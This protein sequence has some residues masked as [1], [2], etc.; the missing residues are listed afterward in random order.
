M[1]PVIDHVQITVKDM[2]VAL[3]FYDQLMP[4]LG[5]DLEKRINAVVG[6]H[7]LHVVEYIHPQLR[8]GINSPR[9]PFAQ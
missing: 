5:F 7:E 2:S 9:E 3:P 6:A 4:L 8:F 1:K